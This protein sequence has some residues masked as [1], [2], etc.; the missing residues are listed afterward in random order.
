M[1]LSCYVFKQ[2]LH[3]GNDR[4]KMLQ[5]KQKKKRNNF[6]NKKGNLENFM[7]F[8]NRFKNILHKRVLKIVYKY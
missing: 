4:L 8:L 1:L 7:L 3:Y 6:K 5:N 2:K